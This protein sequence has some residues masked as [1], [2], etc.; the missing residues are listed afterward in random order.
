MTKTLRSYWQTPVQ[1]NPL[2]RKRLSFFISQELGYYNAIVSGFAGPMRSMPSTFA[3]TATLEEFFAAAAVNQTVSENAAVDSRVLMLARIVATKAVLH[4]DVRRNLAL[5][6]LRECRAQSRALSEPSLSS[7]IETLQPIDPAMKRHV[8]IPR[9]AMT[10]K[11]GDKHEVVVQLP[12]FSEPLTLTRPNSSWNYAYAR[13]GL[14]GAISVDLAFENSSY[15]LRK[16][17]RAGPPKREPHLS[18]VGTRPER[19]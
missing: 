14:D 10:V 9:S 19:A 2:D 12:Y 4:A 13:I 8:Q 6:V 15:V 11:E 16:M 3:Q 7:L 5:A 1:L 18:R 17:D